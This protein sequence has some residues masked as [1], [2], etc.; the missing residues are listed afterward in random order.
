MKAEEGEH[1]NQ[2]NIWN[3]GVRVTDKDSKEK[4]KEGEERAREIGFR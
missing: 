3:E 2:S 1:N 4:S